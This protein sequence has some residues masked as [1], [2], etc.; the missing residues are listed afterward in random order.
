M[1]TSPNLES[2]AEKLPDPQKVEAEKV[3]ANPNGPQV[4][5]PS[6]LE[7]TEEQEK[8]LIDHI[9]TRKESVEGELGRT[10]VTKKGGW[11]TNMAPGT[12]DESGAYYFLPRRE[13][14]DMTYHQEVEWRRALWGGIFQKHN[15]TIPMTRRIVQQQ[16]SR[17]NG[18]FFATDPWFAVL[19]QGQNDE[20]LAKKIDAFT[21]YKFKQGD[22]KEAL[23]AAVQNAFIR[24]ECVVKSTWEER[25]DYHETFAEVL[26]GADGEP[27]I[28][29]DG[30]YIYPED[31]WIEAAMGEEPLTDAMGNP[32]IVLKR[33]QATPLSDFTDGGPDQLEES[34]EER[35][36][37]RRVRLFE[38]VD[39]SPVYYKDFLCPLT[40]R[41]VQTADFCGHIYDQSVSGFVDR[42]MRK[43]EDDPENAEEAMKRIA[44]FIEQA[45]GND[46]SPKSAANMQRSEEDSS[47]ASTLGGYDEGDS[48]RND[49]MMEV[50]EYYV[51]FDA[52][53]DGIS[54]NVVVYVDNET[55]TPLY[56]GYVGAD[57]PDSQR[58]LHTLRVN[59]VEG[60]WYG[61]SQMEVFWQLQTMLDLLVNRWNKA[62]SESGSVTFWN[63]KK[64]LE[65]QRDGNLVLNGGTTYT[66]DPT[67]SDIQKE[68]LSV[69]QIYDIKSD[70]IIKQIEFIMQ[71]AMN[72]SGIMNANDGQMAGMESTKLATGIRNIERSGQEL[73]GPFLSHLD[74]GISSAVKAAL[75]LIVENMDDVEAY[76]FFEGDTRAFDEI[77]RNDLID[78]DLD[79]S[80]E[81]TR[82]RGEQELAQFHQAIEKVTAFYNL[83]F[84]VQTVT[85]PM[86]RNLLKRFE[87]PGGEAIIQEGYFST[88][89]IPSPGGAA[90]PVT[91][92]GQLAVAGQDSKPGQSDALI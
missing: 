74:P 16:I 20:D 89:M 65:G 36:I 27:V 88:A 79:V 73:F 75:K 54:E 19:P 32:V 46:G 71:T 61:R 69:V 53:E 14:F 24:G 86:F 64:T 12:A 41:D 30:D 92:D 70:H 35:K 49:S 51:W 66:P 18:Y 28:A 25:A 33:D 40:A 48:V 87:V 47:V 4:L 31:K 38:G 23:E 84:E 22:V 10:T 56:Y 83:P 62:Q 59:P 21:R 68:I 43:L 55:R 57:F 29:H 6:S 15:I 34:F 90:P 80:I 13:L 1:E 58:P 42:Y 85:A 44:R 72:M 60:R 8:S 63:P 11:W 50:G 17:A 39:L 81:M 45:K 37:R 78:L 9:F 76:E 5:F 2:V 82:Y 7:L 3:A 26:I 77:D 67:V 91:E 52:N